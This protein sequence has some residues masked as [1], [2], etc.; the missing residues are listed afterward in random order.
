MDNNYTIAKGLYI[1]IID[2]EEELLMSEVEMLNKALDALCPDFYE[3]YDAE[4][5]AMEQ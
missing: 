5:K 1:F 4:R 3:R 2:H